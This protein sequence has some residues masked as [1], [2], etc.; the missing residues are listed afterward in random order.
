M[1]KAVQELGDSVSPAQIKE[2]RSILGDDL[3][4]LLDC[5][6]DSETEEEAKERVDAFVSS[7]KDNAVKMLRA[8][9]V[10]DKDQKDLIMKFM[11]EN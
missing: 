1:L 10:L 7:A 4:S 8:R 6:F 3:F 11:G 2:L 9:R 5:A